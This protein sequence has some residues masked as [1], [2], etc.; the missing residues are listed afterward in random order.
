MGGVASV[1][2][3]SQ[4]ASDNTISEICRGRGSSKQQSV[5]RGSSSGT[6]QWVSESDEK[7]RRRPPR[8]SAGSFA[9][10][11][12]PT[13]SPP[14]ANDGDSFRHSTSPRHG[15]SLLLRR[16]GYHGGDD[17][18]TDRGPASQPSLLRPTT[19]SSEP[20]ACGRRSGARSG[21]R[22]GWTGDLRNRY[23]L[24]AEPEFIPANLVLGSAVHEGLA[25]YYRSVMATGDSPEQ[26]VC[27]AAF[28]GTLVGFRKN[29]LPIKDGEDMEAQG[30]ALLKVFYEI[31]YQDPPVVV[32]VE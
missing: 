8:M 28:Y 31:V 24:G 22:W 12:L 1:S 23:V 6:C 21:R 19:P 20:S 15:P 16:R 9:R 13:S 5:R 4:S 2:A 32:G 11:A 10:N 7:M 3:W 27:R 30:E 14:R 25:A 17:D 29:K 26:D 18:C